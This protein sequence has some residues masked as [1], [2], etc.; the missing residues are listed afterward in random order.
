MV[1]HLQPHLDEII[2]PNQ[3]GFLKGRSIV[4]N[5][6]SIEDAIH[7]MGVYPPCCHD[8]SFGFYQSY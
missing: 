7:I 5:I 2:H 6:R 8:R 1:L 3:T 4:N